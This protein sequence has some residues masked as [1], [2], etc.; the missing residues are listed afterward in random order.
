MR[1]KFVV[2]LI[3]LIIISSAC[4][5]FVNANCSASCGPN[6]G[7]GVDQSG[8]QI[9][10]SCSCE[11]MGC[12]CSSQNCVLSCTCPGGNCSGHSSCIIAQ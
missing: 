10:N 8:C 11:G 12:S 3:M 2:L 6:S 1:L 4:Y 7:V 9:S 5:D